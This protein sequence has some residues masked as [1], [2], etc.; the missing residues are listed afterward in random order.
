MGTQEQSAKKRWSGWKIALL[1]ALGVVLIPVTIFAAIVIIGHYR[2]SRPVVYER[3]GLWF[4]SRVCK[5][6]SWTPGQPKT[7]VV[8]HS[9]DA[10]GA[11]SIEARA[12]EGCSRR[13]I[14]GEYALKGNTVSLSYSTNI[15]EG[16]EVACECMFDMTYRISGIP[17]AEYHLTITRTATNVP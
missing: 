6:G 12:V 8:S 3:P 9:W 5:D 10:D 4:E 14:R 17:R 2:Y 7:V 11:L 1:I 13:P 15:P 16:M